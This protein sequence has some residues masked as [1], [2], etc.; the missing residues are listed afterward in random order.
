MGWPRCVRSLVLSICN[1]FHCTVSRT[2]YH[3]I[4]RPLHSLCHASLQTHFITMSLEPTH[5]VR[6]IGRVKLAKCIPGRPEG[7]SKESVGEG[8]KTPCRLKG[9]PPL[10]EG[11]SHK[12]INSYFEQCTSIPVTS[13]TAKSSCDV[14]DLDSY[15]EKKSPTRYCASDSKASHIGERVH[16][17]FIGEYKL[18]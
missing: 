5:T 18:E 17:V 3:G 14:I 9:F 15:V 6:H 12:P 2:E 1:F 8:T 10:P 7:T 11:Y 4:S 13:A 16:A